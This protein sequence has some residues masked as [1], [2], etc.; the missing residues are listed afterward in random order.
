LALLSALLALGAALFPYLSLRR[1]EVILP[2][3][4]LAGGA[5]YLLF[6]VTVIRFSTQ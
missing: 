3:T 1:K 6:I 5:F 4:L 2:T